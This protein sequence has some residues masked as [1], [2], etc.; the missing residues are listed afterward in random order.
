MIRIANSFNRNG[1]ES[2]PAQ[3]MEQIEHFLAEHG[4]AQHRIIWPRKTRTAETFKLYSASG[5][6]CASS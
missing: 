1:T 4:A 5:C 3:V 6:C 2:L